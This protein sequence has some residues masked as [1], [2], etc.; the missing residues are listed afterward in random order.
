LD[1]SALPLLTPPWQ[2]THVGKVGGT[3]GKALG[4][5]K[6]SMH[7]KVFNWWPPIFRLLLAL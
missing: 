1:S 6:A 3:K 2:V 7:F 4:A 5:A